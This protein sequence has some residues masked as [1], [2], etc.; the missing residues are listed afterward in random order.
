MDILTFINSCCLLAAEYLNEAVLE[1]VQRRKKVTPRVVLADLTNTVPQ[2]LARNREAAFTL[3][4]Y[5]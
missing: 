4:H 2:E 5:Q 3:S 1:R